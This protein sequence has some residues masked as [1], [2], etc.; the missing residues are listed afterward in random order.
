MQIKYLAFSDKCIIDQKLPL[1]YQLQDKQVLKLSLFSE[2][3]LYQCISDGLNC[4][5][6]HFRSTALIVWDVPG[7]VVKYEQKC[8]D[9]KM[10]LKDL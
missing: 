1:H 9:F 8:A 7:E 4:C 5:T 6:S 3:R 2:G 10:D